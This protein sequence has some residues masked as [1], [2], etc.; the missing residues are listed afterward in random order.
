MH[1]LFQKIS[2]NVILYLGRL[3]VL[4]FIRSGSP[5]ARI[6]SNANPIIQF[7]QM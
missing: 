1:Y 5:Y 3:T 2:R 7:V 4:E 6:C